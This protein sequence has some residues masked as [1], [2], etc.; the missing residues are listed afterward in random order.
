MTSIDLTALDNFTE[1]KARGA[2]TPLM[3]DIE[4][5]HEDPDQPRQEFEDIVDLATSITEVGIKVPITVRPHPFIDGHYM[6]KFGAR[7]R[8]AALAAGLAK[9]P[10]LLEDRPSDFEQVIE[11]V[12]RRD[13][14]PIE[15]ANFIA[16]KASSGL[17]HSEIAKKLGLSR[18][19]VTKY[20]A[21]IN[22]PAEIEAVYSSGRNTSPDTLFDLRALYTQF[23][24]DTK[25]WLATD[26]EI[27]RRSVAELRHKLI[28]LTQSK[29][30]GE[31][32]SMR[33]SRKLNIIR[34]DEVRRPVIVVKVKGR[35]GIIILNRRAAQ[36]D[37]VLVKWDESGEVS[38]V[39]CRD[40]RVLRF[41]DAGRYEPLNR[42]TTHASGAIVPYPQT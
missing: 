3:L 1:P 24:E 9:I 10:A 33:N 5:V 25:A 7:R 39:Q 31:T 8:R 30:D 26:A 13:L 29:G 38:T 17:K 2:G 11:N 4:L 23:P 21:L 14:T 19:A 40:I 18:T 28:E 37:H 15:M 27:S 42:G 16:D 22:P 20:L 34:P 35:F 36:N 6:V 32:R 41:D 12:H